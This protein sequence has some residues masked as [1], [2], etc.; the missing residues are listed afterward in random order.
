MKFLTVF[1]VLCLVA[2]STQ[3]PLYKD[4]YDSVKELFNESQCMNIECFSFKNETISIA[5]LTANTCPFL[6]C[7][8]GKKLKDVTPGNETA[9]YPGCCDTPV[10]Q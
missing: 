8:E 4:C 6:R 10:C 9:V 5:T 3:S 2:Y 1:A 7:E